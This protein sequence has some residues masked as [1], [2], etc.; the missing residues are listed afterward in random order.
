MTKLADLEKEKR[1]DRQEPAP[2][3]KEDQGTQRAL[4]LIDKLLDEFHLKQARQDAAF[5]TQ[6]DAALK[7]A[8]LQHKLKAA[9]EREKMWRERAQELEQQNIGQKPPA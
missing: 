5:L 2:A 8:T 4:N 6:P 7:G 3:E 9:L 1:A